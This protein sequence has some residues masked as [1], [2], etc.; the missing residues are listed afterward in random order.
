[1][2]ANPYAL[3]KLTLD[4]PTKWGKIHAALRYNYL[5]V[6]DYSDN[7][8]RKLLPSW[9]KS[10]DIIDRDARSLAAG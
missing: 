1:M 10:L 2:T 3:R 5:C 4:G 8:L 9:L 6:R 7:A